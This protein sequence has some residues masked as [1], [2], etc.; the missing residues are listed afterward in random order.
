MSHAVLEDQDEGSGKYKND[1]NLSSQRGLVYHRV[2]QKKNIFDSIQKGSLG[3]GPVFAKAQRRNK[4]P[5]S[6]QFGPFL[7]P[8]FTQDGDNKMKI[9]VQR[10]NKNPP[11]DKKGN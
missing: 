1:P 4:L 3:L 5:F 11:Q 6:G 7:T 8:A 9:K 2:F 10:K